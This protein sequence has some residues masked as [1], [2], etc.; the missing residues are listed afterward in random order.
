MANTLENTDVDFLSLKQAE[1]QI[2]T[3]LDKDTT[4]HFN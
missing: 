1:E 3:Q 2:T 4:Q